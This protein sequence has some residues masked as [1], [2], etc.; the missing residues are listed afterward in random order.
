MARGAKLRGERDAREGRK[1]HMNGRQTE[2]EKLLTQLREEGIAEQ[3]VLDALA[4]VPRHEFVSE[5]QSQAA[6]ENRPLTIGHEQTISQPYIVALMTELAALPERA[7][8]LELGTGSGYQTA[9]LSVLGA[10]VYTIE[11]I[12]ALAQQARAVLERLGLAAQVHFRV[13]DGSGG[14]PDEAPFDAIIVTAAP[15]SVPAVLQEQLV[16]GGKLIIP[17]GSPDHQELL[18]ITRSQHGYHQ[19][20]VVPVRFVTMTGAAAQ[21]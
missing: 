18:V 16:L 12:E 19:R 14:W 15:G 10:T 20:S 8:V 17:V 6:Y 21:G 5:P 9:I 3:R 4:R 2:L 13:G 1:K 11:I 7:R